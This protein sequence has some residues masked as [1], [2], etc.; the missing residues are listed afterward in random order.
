[1]AQSMSTDVIVNVYIGVH[2]V[3]EP[4]VPLTTR[5]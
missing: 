1:M 3:N 2:C 5:S 4:P